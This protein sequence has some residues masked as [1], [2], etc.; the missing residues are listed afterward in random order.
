ME[1]IANALKELQATALTM[2]GRSLTVVLHLATGAI[3]VKTM[4][5]AG[6]QALRIETYS[7]DATAIYIVPVEQ[8]ILSA[9]LHTNATEEPRR[10]IGFKQ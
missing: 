8:A 3:Q 6:T 4:A 1:E 5:A 9:H 7:S 2:T 10:F